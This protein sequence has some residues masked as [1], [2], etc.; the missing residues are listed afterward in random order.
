MI[1]SRPSHSSRPLRAIYGNTRGAVLP[2]ALMAIAMLAVLGITAIQTTTQQTDI[3]ANYKTATQSLYAAEGG[4]YHVIRKYRNDPSLYTTTKTAT[5]MGL[6]AAKPNAANLGAS[7][8]YW[9]PSLTYAAGNPPAYVDIESQGSVIGT[10]SL[11]RVV[12]RVAYA[13]GVVSEYG[14]FGDDEIRMVGTSTVDSYNSCNA[15]YDPLNPGDNIAVGTNATGGGSIELDADATINGDAAVGPGGNAHKRQD[16]PK[17]IYFM[18]ICSGRQARPGGPG[19]YRAENR[20][21]RL[22]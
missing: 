19:P 5:E 11:A 13:P 2:M 21:F 20:L 16:K 14:V 17:G 8:A 10:T 4:V 6:P 15:A 18:R 22:L 3:T 1:Y 9:F 12:V 7:K